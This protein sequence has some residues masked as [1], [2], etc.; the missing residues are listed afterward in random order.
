MLLPEKSLLYRNHIS[1]FAVCPE[2]P[3]LNTSLQQE[4]G[5]RNSHYHR[6]P[7]GRYDRML[8]QRQRKTLGP[9]FQ[10]IQ[11]GL[12]LGSTAALVDLLVMVLGGLSGMEWVVL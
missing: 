2:H 4:A 12:D 3:R 7:I 5:N 11:G 9:E 8:G 10:T 1:P 6:S